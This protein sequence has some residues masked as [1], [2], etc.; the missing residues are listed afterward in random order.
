MLVTI[1]KLSIH[2]VF[3][4]HFFSF[5]LNGKCSAQ[6]HF[7]WYINLAGQLEGHQMVSGVSRRMLRSN[8][9]SGRFMDVARE[10]LEEEGVKEGLDADSWFAVVNPKAKDR[11]KTI[12]FR[13]KRKNIFIFIVPQR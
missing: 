8:L 6:M 4:D 11:N 7:S 13:R 12:F 2:I 9:R 5:F 3:S 1:I 10:K